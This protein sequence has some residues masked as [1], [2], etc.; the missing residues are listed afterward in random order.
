MAA[1][2]PQKNPSTF[3]H[4]GPFLM[5]KVQELYPA[6]DNLA[7]SVVAK[8]EGIC[9]ELK[10]D[11]A[12]FFAILLPYYFQKME[13]VL[14]FYDE[15]KLIDRF[16]GS[17]DRLPDLFERNIFPKGTRSQDTAPLG[18][19]TF[20]SSGGKIHR[21]GR[22]GWMVAP[23]NQI[24][25]VISDEHAGPFDLVILIDPPIELDIAMLDVAN[26]VVLRFLP[27]GTSY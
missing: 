14:C 13:S 7:K 24:D 27:E 8:S 10:K 20:I 6:L 5:S 1:K 26:P 17:R 16:L 21:V 22:P 3:E 15:K 2:L 19:G 18:F 9:V 4:Y 11:D 25:R 23:Y 12:L